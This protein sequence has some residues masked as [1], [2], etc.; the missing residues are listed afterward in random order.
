MGIDLAQVPEQS[1][2]DPPSVIASIHEEE[3]DMLPVRSDT[4]LSDQFL[5]VKR[6]VIRYPGKVFIVMNAFPE[7]FRPF[8]RIIRRLIL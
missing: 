3:A 8:R 2:S 7:F 4:D 6:S 5:S 1:G